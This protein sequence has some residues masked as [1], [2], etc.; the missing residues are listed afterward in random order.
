MKC[1]I[2]H[3]TDHGSAFVSSQTQ[4]I[5]NILGITLIHSRVGKPAGRGKIERFFRTVREQFLRPLD[6]DE[7]KSLED[8]DV[9]F[10]TWLENEYHRSPHRGLNKNTPLEVWV[11]KADRIIAVDPTVNY[12]RLFYHEASRKVHKDSTLTLQGMLYEVPS[13]L[14]GERVNLSYDP[15]LPAHKR[16]LLVSHQGQESG[17]ARIVDSYAN[18]KVRRGNLLKD[19][20]IQQS[21]DPVSEVTDSAPSP[22]DAGLS[23]SC[24]RPHKPQSEVQK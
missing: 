10:H 3:F 5:L 17:T 2:R 6:V 19:P 11:E 12:T 1:R 16:T 8:L 9:R 22:L 7:L 18:A 23:A 14:I 4:R 15:F 20:V 24:I 13:V 21:E